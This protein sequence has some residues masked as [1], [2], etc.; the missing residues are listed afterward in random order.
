MSED[1]ENIRAS[2]QLKSDLDAAGKTL[3]GEAMEVLKKMPG[4]RIDQCVQY[5]RNNLIPAVIRK[6]GEKSA[7]LQVFRECV[8]LLLWGAVLYD[9]LDHQVR[10]N[11][12][13]RL[14][15]Q[16]LIERLLLM[17][18]ELTK[19]E[20]VEDLHLTDALLRIEKGVLERLKRSNSGKKT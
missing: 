5:L 13:L 19:Y 15:K 20:T 6:S 16:I 1:L 9:R 12:L 11:G 2:I 7:D 10:V 4:Y 3:H 14:E 8:D 18:S 17:E